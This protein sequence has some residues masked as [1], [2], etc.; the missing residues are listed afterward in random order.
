MQK[1]VLLSIPSDEFVRSGGRI[2][3]LKRRQ[4][5]MWINNYNPTLLRLWQG[6]MDIQPCG[7][8]EAIAFYIAKYVGKSEP[9]QLATGVNEAI[10]EIQK[11]DCEYIIHK[12]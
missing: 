3:H 9:Q 5:D 2:C 12:G 10:K 11:E 7:S 8:N 6:N 4:Q 1:L